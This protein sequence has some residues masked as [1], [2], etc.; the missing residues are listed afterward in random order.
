MLELF[1][2]AFK[3]STVMKNLIYRVSRFIKE[4]RIVV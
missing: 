4:R 1:L 2:F 3:T